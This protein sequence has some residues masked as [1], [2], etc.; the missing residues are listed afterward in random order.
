[1]WESSER[2][3]SSL[4]SL[5]EIALRTRKHDG[6]SESFDTFGSSNMLCTESIT[7]LDS[8]Y[9]PG[10]DMYA[11]LEGFAAQVNSFFFRRHLYNLLPK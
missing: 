8:V 2:K 6:T 4:P 11:G 3:R 7:D 5:D 10:A 1:M 9:S